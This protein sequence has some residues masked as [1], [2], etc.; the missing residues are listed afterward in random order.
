MQSCIH[1]SIISPFWSSRDSTQTSRYPLHCL[2]RHLNK[3][4]DKQTESLAKDQKADFFFC[5]VFKCQDIIKFPEGF[6]KAIRNLSS[7]SPLVLLKIPYGIKLT[8]S[9]DIKIPLYPCAASTRDCPPWFQQGKAFVVKSCEISSHSVVHVAPPKMGKL[10]LLFLPN[11]NITALLD[12]VNWNC[13]N[14]T[15]SPGCGH[16]HLCYPENSVLWSDWGLLATDFTAMLLW[17]DSADLQFLFFRQKSVLD[18]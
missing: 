4:Q 7:E 13:K 16:A 12:N 1:P 9:F 11:E 2:A 14:S 18:W 3:G 15:Q 17:S 8:A 10:I 5:W 6:S